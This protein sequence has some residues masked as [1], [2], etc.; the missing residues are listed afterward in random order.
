MVDA[1]LRSASILNEVSGER[2]ADQTRR[3]LIANHAICSG[4]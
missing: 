2:H 1:Q 3:T 4:L